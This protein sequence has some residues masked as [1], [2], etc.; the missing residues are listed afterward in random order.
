MLLNKVF[1]RFFKL[2]TVHYIMPYFLQG[3]H[4]NWKKSQGPGFLLP[5]EFD[6]KFQWYYKVGTI[7]DDT[8][9]C[10]QTLQKYLLPLTTTNF[11]SWAPWWSS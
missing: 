1:L 6:L 8:Q 2:K 4:L 7:L 5:V 10:P 11:T 3:K 9:I